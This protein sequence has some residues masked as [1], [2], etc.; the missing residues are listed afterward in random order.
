MEV[1]EASKAVCAHADPAVLPWVR[2]VAFPMLPVLCGTNW[3]LIIQSTYAH[4]LNWGSEITWND[5]EI[6]FPVESAEE[7]KIKW[8]RTQKETYTNLASMLILSLE[9]TQWCYGNL[10]PRL[11]STV[12][13][14][15]QKHITHCHHHSTIL[16]RFVREM[17]VSFCP[18]DADG[19]VICGNGAVFL[20]VLGVEQ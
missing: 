7:K 1:Y 19:Y 17:F 16:I 18:R 11:L 9:G 12:S 10:L 13:E 8:M 4:A 5:G 20:Y 6:H 2:L 14:N 15:K 3:L